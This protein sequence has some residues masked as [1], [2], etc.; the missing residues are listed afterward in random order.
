VDG[1]DDGR[2]KIDHAHDGGEQSY[3]PDPPGFER[4][5]DGGQCCTLGLFHGFSEVE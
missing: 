5:A 3:Y 2:K 4:R 1:R